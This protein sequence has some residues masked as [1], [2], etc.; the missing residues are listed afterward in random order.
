MLRRELDYMPFDK[1]FETGNGNTELCHAT[2]YEV[3]FEGHD[4][5]DSSNWW[6]EFIDNDGNLHYGR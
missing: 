1:R 2:G 4:S 5:N 6:N 3:C